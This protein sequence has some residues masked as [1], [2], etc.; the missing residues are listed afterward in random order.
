V[1]V[2]SRDQKNL[3]ATTADEVKT[4]LVNQ[5]VE[6]MSE[7]LMHLLRRKATIELRVSNRA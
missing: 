6:L 5:R 4:Q 1:I 3:A 7:Q 2:C